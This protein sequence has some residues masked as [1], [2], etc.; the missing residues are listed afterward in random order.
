MTNFEPRWHFVEDEGM[1]PE[2]HNK[3]ST[4]CVIADPNGGKDFAFWGFQTVCP[5]QRAWCFST[6][7][8]GTNV[9]GGDP[10]HPALIT[11]WMPIPPCVKPEAYRP[12]M[13]HAE[14]ALWAIGENKQEPVDF[15]RYINK[16]RSSTQ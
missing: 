7:R 3:P 4:L 2:D 6:P 11:A 5:N 8:V 12:P 15:M 14:E 9:R 16:L 10:I 13:T 1:P